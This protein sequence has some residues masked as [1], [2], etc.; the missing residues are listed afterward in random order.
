M[1]IS[2]LLD[3]ITGSPEYRGQ[4]EHVRN[5][6]ARPAQYGELDR[7][8]HSKLAGLLAEQGI[9]RL[10]SH[11]SQAI[12]AVLDG[13][14]VTVVA[15]TA[16]GKTLC[17]LVPI[18][19][20]IYTRPTSRALMI[21]PT[22]ALAQDQLRKLADLG[23]GAAFTAE[24]YDGDTP[25]DRRRKI[26]KEAQVVLTNPDMLH[27]GI[28]PYHYTWA[29]FFRS[30]QFVVL[31]E[32]H[33]Y[34]GVFGSHAA[35][36][37]RRLRRIAR[38]YGADPQF[39]CCSATIANPAE[40]VQDLTGLDSVLVSN[41]GA[42]TGNRALVMWNPPVLPKTKGQRRS[43]NLEAADLLAELVQRDVRTIAFTLARS[44]A[45]LILRYVREGLTVQGAT[46]LAGKVLAYRGGYLP[47]ERRE[48]ERKLFDGELLGVVSTTA[49]ELGV[50][51]GGLDAVIMAGYPGSIASTWQQAGR[52]GRGKQ[53]ALAVMVGLGGGIH[54]YLMRNPDYLLDTS[55]ERV[56]VDPQ[57]RYILAAHL[58]CA[59][60]ELAISDEET[61][62]F[63][64][65]MEAI[66]AILGDAGYLT[67]RR[68]WYWIDP[69]GYPAGQ[70]SIRS[71]SGEAYTIVTGEGEKRALLGTMDGASAFRMIH[72][73]AMYL[74]GGESYLV[75]RLDLEERVATVEPSDAGYY[76]VALTFSDVTVTETREERALTG[77]GGAKL[78]EMEVTSRVGGYRKLRQVTDQDLGTTDL[79]LPASSYETVGVG[80][81]VLDSHAAELRAQGHDLMGSIH[82][83][84]HAMIALL[85]LFALCDPH[86][87]AG[88][89]HLAH[90]DVGGP[91][92]FIW[93]GYPG[94]VGISETVFGRLEDLIAATADM[95]AQCPCEA[96]CPSCVQSPQCGDGN[97]PL[98]KE[99]AALLARLMGERQAP[100]SADGGG[101]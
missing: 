59:A 96:G 11:Q 78:V 44:Q 8:L 15:G 85:P 87:V 92:I 6:P 84:E 35:N 93:D 25:R 66:L 3:A 57:N 36:V 4:V 56:V 31:D 29:E 94:G 33:V 77:G 100:A 50:D 2:A 18:A 75:T 74:H 9:E 72:E 64:P 39:I 47:A 65:Q 63:G 70:V 19:E 27:V 13:E 12:N 99:G 24:T 95:V 54:Q 48:I 58:L 41:D 55:S 82:A 91:A 20:A 53:D 5:V 101:V 51:I 89:S 43:A 60:Y 21:Y 90:P 71:A 52:A 28:L 22:K 80:L 34:R 10:Y 23:A 49:L 68:Q 40:L 62:L 37:I 14:N 86:D 46:R 42:P 83:L 98:D 38:H 32:V 69:V 26:K 79:D 97:H 61:A 45:E 1:D 81:P 16:S 76:T 73:G 67:K 88:L 17:Y 30:L 7:E